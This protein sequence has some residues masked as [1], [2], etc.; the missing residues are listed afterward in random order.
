M[1]TSR[2][3]V[4]LLC[5]AVQFASGCGATESSNKPLNR[6]VILISIDTLRTDRL[7]AYGY[8]L[9][10]SPSLDALAARGILFENA[11]STAPWT[12]P[13]HASLLTGLYPTGHG[14]R[15][16]EHRLADNIPTLATIV[17]ERGFDTAAFVNVLFLG[18]G[19][20]LTQGFDQFSISPSK[21]SRA[22]AAKNIIRD[23]QQ[24]LDAHRERPIFLFAHFFDVHSDYQSLPRYEAMFVSDQSNRFN[25]ETKQI[26]DAVFGKIPAIEPFEA[27]H[28]SLLYSAGIRQLDDELG[29]FFGWLRARGWLDDTLL[30]VTSD[31]GEEF[32]DH[33]GMIHG[34]SHYQ[35]LIAVPLIMT[36]AGVPEGIRISTPVSL[37]DLV[38][39]VLGILGIESPQQIDGRD[40][41]PLWESE[42]GWSFDD[43]VLL[44]ETGPTQHDLLRSVRRGDHKFI[45]NIKTGVREL[46]DL[47]EDPRETRNLAD[48][49]PAL[50]QS[51]ATALEQLTS[52]GRVPEPVR[53]YTPKMEQRLRA[54][55][56]L[57]P[58]D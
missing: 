5:A 17:K 34:S 7:G 52:G 48:Q 2:L 27:E 3:Y 56:Y 40:L 9:P 43:R 13:A 19:S 49:Q 41:R 33:G 55:G 20:G 53:S 14:V 57:Q 38:P 47:R 42:R 37:V 23:I 16:V 45:V 46:Y 54:L 18:A 22:G 4:A 50:A 29:R 58:A 8:H 28:L 12:T 39:T 31:H 1:W 26:S 21:P 32:L 25:G 35:E 24:W 11:I 10:T 36:G 15:T 51:L 44:V 6:N 30:I